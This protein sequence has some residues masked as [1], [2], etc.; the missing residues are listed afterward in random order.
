MKGI[1][2]DFLL[3]LQFL[4]RLPINLSLPCEKENFRRGTMFFPIVGFVIGGL[5]WILFFLTMTFLPGNTI[6]I[7][8]LLLGI[9]ITGGLHIDGLGDTCDGFFAFKVK[10]RII[11]IMKD[12][13]IG[14]YSCI[15][16]IIDLLLKYSSTTNLIVT[17]N[18]LGIIAAPVIGRTAFVFLF[19]IGRQAKAVG[20]GNLFIGN[21]GKKELFIAT[22]L[23]YIICGILV[24][25]MKALVLIVAALALTYVFNRFCESKIDGLTG[26]T[27]GANNEIIEIFMLILAFSVRL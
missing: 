19:Y 25:P 26:D 24:G 22:I 27:L 3:M 10:D 2:Q 20:T 6:A 12:S 15:A 17:G 8:I 13:R 16:I 9:L 1:V 23:G 14:T 5:Q 4:T 11:E 7:F 21:V 18:S